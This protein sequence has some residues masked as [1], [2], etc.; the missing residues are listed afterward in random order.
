[1]IHP[2]DPRSVQALPLALALGAGWWVVGLGA[3]AMLAHSA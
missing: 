3:V 2:S 1:M